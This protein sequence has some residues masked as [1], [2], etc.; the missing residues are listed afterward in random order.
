[1]IWKELSAE[2]GPRLHPVLRLLIGL[3]VLASFWPPGRIVAEYGFDLSAT[4]V[5]NHVASIFARGDTKN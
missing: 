3:I 5:L 2:R 1:M 4:D